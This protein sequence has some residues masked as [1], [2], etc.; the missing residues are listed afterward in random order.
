MEKEDKMLKKRIILILIAIFSFWA[1]H[2]LEKIGTIFGKAFDIL[3]PFILGACI[4]F[5][6]NMPM[7][8]FE[9]KLSNIKNK[10][11]KSVLGKKLLR[12]ISF[13]LAFITIIFILVIVINLILPELINVVN[14]LIENIPYYIEKLEE[15][16]ENMPSLE[17]I[18]AETNFDIEKMKTEILNKIPNLLSSSISL[19]GSVFSGVST[20]VIALIFAIYILTGKEKIKK[21]SIRILYAYCSGEKA[22]KIINIGNLTYKTF[23]NFFSV[24]CLEA[25]ILGTLCMIGM[26][27]LQIPYAVTI[28]ILIGVT[29]LIP[30][31]GAFIGIIVGAILIAS[32]DFVKVVTFIIFVLLLQ[33]FEGNIIYPRVVGNS[34]GLPGMLVLFAVSVGGSLFGIVGMLLGVPFVSVIYSLI[35]KDVDQRLSKENES[36]NRA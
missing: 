18:I 5:I 7:R 19:I 33:Q 14:I 2:N 35:K 34:V 15:L 12:A 17:E 9:N 4:A 11:G 16:G 26:L 1:I 6:L 32:V 23:T 31:V 29:A 25:T 27:I 21:Q 8:F 13:V 22:D 20:F 3:F 28:G 10:K 30:I 36:I 24:Q